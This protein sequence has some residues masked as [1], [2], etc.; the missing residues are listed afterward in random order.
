MIDNLELHLPLHCQ[1][2]GAQLL[3]ALAAIVICSMDFVQLCLVALGAVMYLIMNMPLQRRSKSPQLP[4]KKSC[5]APPSFPGSSSYRS[6]KSPSTAAV[7]TSLNNAPPLAR[8]NSMNNKQ[9]FS[10][11]TTAAA[12][13]APQKYV[14][15]KKASLHIRPA[16]ADSSVVGASQSCRSSTSSNSSSTTLQLTPNAAAVAARICNDFEAAKALRGVQP[17]LSGKKDGSTAQPVL[18]LSFTS[19]TWGK[20]V[21]ELVARITPTAYTDG[22]VAELAKQVKLQLGGMVRDVEVTGFSGSELMRGTAFG[23]AVPEVDI[24]ACLSPDSISACFKGRVPQPTKAGADMLKVQKKAVR[25]FTE[26]LVRNGKFK[27]RRSAFRGSEPKVTLLASAEL[28]LHSEPIPFDLT[29]NSTSPAFNAALVTEA[30]QLDSRAKGLIL[31]VKRWAK[32]RAMCH[33]A[34]GHLSP[35][36]WTLMT[37]FFLQAGLPETE[38]PLLPPVSDFT[39]LAA[40]TGATPKEKASNFVASTSAATVG[41]LFKLFVEFYKDFD[42]KTE[43]VSVLSGTRAAPSLRLPLNVIIDGGATCVGPSIEDPFD[44]RNNV[45]MG[46]TQVAWSHLQSELARASEI[47]AAGDDASLSQ[48]L[49]PWSNSSSSA[50]ADAEDQGADE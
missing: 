26:Q 30:G 22:V 18:P 41:S 48:L 25:L 17:T 2:R 27:F 34:K 36:A 49:E 4:P 13:T 44:G 8:G 12:A 14:P 50:E 19:N 38:K 11:A 47:L 37:I 16:P 33:A 28:G 35:Y 3:L 32:D 43:G 42:F 6:P 1:G 31:L 7:P 39:T 24:V 40:V 20:Q 23:V 21:D 46:M 9:P 5:A 29:F 45:A 10:Q 15:P